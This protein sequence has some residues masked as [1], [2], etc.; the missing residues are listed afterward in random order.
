MEHVLANPVIIILTV[1]ESVL[2]RAA[3]YMVDATV[4]PQV[5]EHAHVIFYTE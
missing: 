2:R 3:N 1:V 5:M 4:L